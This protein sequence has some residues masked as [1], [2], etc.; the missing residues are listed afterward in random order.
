MRK[1]Y[2]FLRISG[3]ILSWEGSH[4]ENLQALKNLDVDRIHVDVFDDPSGIPEINFH[5]T[6]LQAELH[7][8]SNRPEIFLPAIREKGISRV[9]FQFENLPH[10][11]EP[12]TIPGAKIGLAVLPDTA[13]ERVHHLLRAMDYVTVMATV[14]GVSGQPFNLEAF[15]QI[16]R[17]RA[18][19]PNLP[20]HVDGGVTVSITGVL[21]RLGVSEVVIGSFLAKSVDKSSD[22]LRA[23]LGF[24]LSGV[25]VKEAMVPLNGTP[26][27]AVADETSLGDL[28]HV[29]EKKERGYVILTDSRGYVTGVFT[30]GDVRRVLLSS[31]AVGLETPLALHV[32][33]ERPF[34]HVD[35]GS[36]LIEAF[37]HATRNTNQGRSITFL[38]VVSEGGLLRG[39]VDFRRLKEEIS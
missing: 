33:R 6:P 37:Q 32:N 21:Y 22:A 35:I 18:E 13:L 36:S 15:R 34:A 2:R 23:K 17:L 11:W 3:S 9:L 12:P 24:P 1:E 16:E 20:T 39:V 14:P 4:E 28:V 31:S 27:L 5:E 8:V 26:T 10:D 29:L 30:D 19:W 7:I 38:P 25:T